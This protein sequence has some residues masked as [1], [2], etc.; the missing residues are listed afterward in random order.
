MTNGNGKKKTCF[1]VMGFGKK[2]DFQSS[3]Q[4]VLDLDR[5]YEGIIEPTVTACGLECI[6]ADKI[7]HSTVIDKPMYEQLQEA[8]LVIADL[9]TSNANAIYE[10]GVR[11]AL[12]PYTTIVIAEEGFSFPFDLNHLSI[13]KYRHLGEDIGFQEV[14]RVRDV[15][16][17]KIEV[18]VGKKGV[19]SPVYLFLPSLLDNDAATP[20]P[21]PTAQPQDDKSFA[22]LMQTLLES[23]KFAKRLVATSADWQPVVDVANR[24]IKLQPTDPYIIQQLALGTYKSKL[25]DPLQALNK[26]KEILQV[27]G[28]HTSSDAETVGLWGAIHKR[29][30]ELGKDRGDLNTAVR[31]YA[32][33]YY[34][35]DDYYN[36]INF[37]Y[38][39]NVRA[40]I[41]QGDD[42][43]SDRVIARR[44]RNEVLALCDVALAIP[45]IKDDD[46]F[47]VKATK[48]ESLLGLGRK[49]EADALRQELLAAQP[50]P[51]KWMIETMDD[52]LGKL[53]ALSP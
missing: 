35:K 3:P 8:D 12:R 13:L 41:S 49:P 18:L 24:L 9:S 52:Q 34:I 6:R 31:A 21:A 16:T 48:V 23:L 28:P 10:L 27:L 30:W 46:K 39:L 20:P 15:L 1:V 19:D 22:E 33:G 5:T 53:A 43:I 7:I 26:A 42:A 14:K 45:T 25:P 51:A 44:T 47:W 36:G 17:K 2:T 4:R 37:A 32:R 29:L 50:S 11:H 38:L 40:A